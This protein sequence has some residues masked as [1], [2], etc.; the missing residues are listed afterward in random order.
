MIKIINKEEFEKNV[1]KSKELTLVDFF[2]NW[3][4]PCTS[5]APV[6]EEIED[7]N[8]NFEIVKID[9]DKEPDLAIDYEVE[10][11]PTMIIF[12]DGKELDRLQGVVSKANILNKIESLM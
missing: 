5:M 4:G 7:E 9:I 3:C 12:K 6:L 8:N 1:L 2:A 11:I 10:F